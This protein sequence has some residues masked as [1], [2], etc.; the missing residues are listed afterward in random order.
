MDRRLDNLIARF[1][2]AQDA[3]VMLLSTMGVPMPASNFDWLA[4]CRAHGISGFE[5]NGVKL[6]PHGFG[7]EVRQGNSS[8]DFDWGPNGESDAFDAW[9]LFNFASCNRLAEAYAY[10]DVEQWLLQGHAGGD[11]VQVGSLYVDPQRRAN[12]P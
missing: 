3:A 2:E 10:E 12:D 4:I 1:R 8:V 11:L 7:I 5:A 9:R 6:I